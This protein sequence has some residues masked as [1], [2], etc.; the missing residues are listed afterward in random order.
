MTTA[1]PAATDFTSASTQGA[2]KTAYANQRQFLADLLGTSGLSADARTAL[3]LGSMATQAASAV[4]I[5]GGAIDGTTLGATTRASA[6]V[7]TLDASGDSIFSGNV[8]VGGAAVS[9]WTAGKTIEL[10]GSQR[11]TI[12][13]S[14]AGYMYLSSNVK[15]GASGAA[16]FNAN[17]YANWIQI[18]GDTF[19]FMNGGTGSAGGAITGTSVISLSSAGVLSAG[20]GVAGSYDTGVQVANISGPSTSG[21]SFYSTSGWSPNAANATIRMGRDATTSRSINAGGSINASGADLAEYRLTGEL[22]RPV[23]KGQVIGYQADGKV[24]DKWSLSI[25]Q[26]RWQIKTTNPHVV[27][28]DAWGNE[29]IIG[30]QPKQP[31]PP[32]L[33]YEGPGMPEEP[34]PMPSLVLFVQ[35]PEPVRQSDEDDATFKVRL[36]TWRDESARVDARI[37]EAKTAYAQ[38]QSMHDQL[39]SSYRDALRDWQQEQQT[40]AARVEAAQYTF[41]TITMVAFENDMDAWRARLEVQRQTVDRIAY[42]GEVPMLTGQAKPKKAGDRVVPIEGSDDTIDV[43]FVDPGEIEFRDYVRCCGTVTSVREDGSCI[44]AVKVG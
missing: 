38:L 19:T 26:S 6:K 22:R 32:T 16:T 7:T 44:V 23:A 42:N 8:G 39:V 33:Q 4:A 40:F 36:A 27:G 13:A 35:P 11:P 31:E 30:A 18:T 1:L 20:V 14:P 24:T 21:V 10:S 15:W 3:G 12:A 37:V 34:M 41:E 25:G 29:E 43:K 9:G 17:G 2:A 28:G 5:T